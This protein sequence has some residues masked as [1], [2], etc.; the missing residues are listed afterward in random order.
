M[1]SLPIH[2]CFYTWQGE[3]VH[4]GKAAYFIRTFGCPV[5]CPWCDSAGTWHPE[6][7]PETIDKYTPHELAVLARK[8]PCEFV[9]ITGGE[10]A[11]HDLNPLTAALKEVG[12]VSHLETSGGFEIKGDFFWVT[13]SPKW[14][15]MPLKENIERAD[16]IKIIVEDETTIER[17]MEEIG[18]FISTKHVWLNPEW[19]QR[20]NPEVLKSISMKIK[21]S[22]SPF[23][24]GYQVHKLYNV[25]QID[26]NV[27]PP[28]PLG[29]KIENGF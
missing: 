2:E 24:A 23:R 14:W 18:D 7:V 6:Y 27:K 4:V 20:D 17:W 9:V 16:E 12:L 1:K 19:S 5:K 25:D 8:H 11:I 13:V 29:G 22:G 26:P 10:P 28:A 21:K 15:K 3:G